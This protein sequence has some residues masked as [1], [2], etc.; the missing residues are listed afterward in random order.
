METIKE[1]VLSALSHLPETA[2]IDDYIC[3]KMIIGVFVC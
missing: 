3:N 2:D 1:E